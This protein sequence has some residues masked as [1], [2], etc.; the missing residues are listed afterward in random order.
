M[1]HGFPPFYYWKGDALVSPWLVP[2]AFPI[3]HVQD[4]QCWQKQTRNP[5]SQSSILLPGL[6]H[7]GTLHRTSSLQYGFELQFQLYFCHKI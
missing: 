4:M 6:K 7:V 1:G 3:L 5:D 2:T